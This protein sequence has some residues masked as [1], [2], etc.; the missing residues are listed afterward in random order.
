MDAV[1]C[2]WQMSVAGLSPFRESRLTRWFRR[3]CFPCHHS[4]RKPHSVVRR[5]CWGQV[6]TTH[7]EFLTAS[8]QPANR[9]PPWNPDFCTSYVLRVTDRTTEVRP[10]S[11]DLLFSIFARNHLIIWPSA[12][13]VFFSGM[14]G[15]GGLQLIYRQ[16]QLTGG[17]C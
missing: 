12:V 8:L 6:H 5:S 13:L 11:F 10:K 16:I 4:S 17:C 3:S 1:P 15:W 2:A 14:V 9:R 7:S